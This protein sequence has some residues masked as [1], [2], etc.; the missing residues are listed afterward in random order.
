MPS[1]RAGAAISNPERSC[2]DPSSPRD[3]QPL[4]GAVV[5]PPRSAILAV[6]AAAQRP[7]AGAGKGTQPGDASVA[8][9]Q[10]R[11]RIGFV[12]ARLRSPP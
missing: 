10:A 11:R 6:G 9:T 1:F 5:A 2:R 12:S 4:G 7:G 3:R 8:G